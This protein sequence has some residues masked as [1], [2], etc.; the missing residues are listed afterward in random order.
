MAKDDVISV[1]KELVD[2]LKGKRA[3]KPLDKILEDIPFDKVAETPEGLPYNIWQLVEH[4]RIS[5]YDILDFTRNP[6]YKE[7]NWPDDYWPKN[8]KPENEEQWQDSIK[9]VKEYREEMI[10]IVEDE[11]NDLLEP[12]MHGS[13]Q[14]IFR[15]ATLMAEHEAHH[16]GQVIV[17]KRLLGMM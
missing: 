4:I 12:L 2:L 14:T 13:G 1:R 8:G 17:L 15:E 5:A 7:I 10:Q 11:S 3:F 16:T 9:A 6:E